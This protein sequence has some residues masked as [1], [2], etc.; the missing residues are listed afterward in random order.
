M[1]DNNIDVLLTINKIT[2]VLLDINEYQGKNRAMIIA[3]ITCLANKGILNW[4]N[5]EC[6]KQANF[7]EGVCEDEQSDD[8]R[9]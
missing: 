8:I 9:N 7:D 1:S 3:L 4:R 6:I 2:D 5:I